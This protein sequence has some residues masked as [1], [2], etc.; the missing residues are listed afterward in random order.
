[1]QAADPAY[2]FV[3]AEEPAV[4]TY[5]SV[6][7]GVPEERLE[8][9]KAQI[10]GASRT[11]LVDWKEFRSNPDKYL[12]VYVVRNDYGR[13]DVVDGMFELLQKFPGQPFSLT[14]NGGI[15]LTGRDHA[16]ARSTMAMYTADPDSF[17][18]PERA[19]DPVHPLNHLGPLLKAETATRK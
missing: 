17:R 10:A 14:W 4:T 18:P 7:A 11:W 1:M 3:R 2:V 9:A 16:H 13:I 8:K 15:A 19:S 6:G 5:I 12:R